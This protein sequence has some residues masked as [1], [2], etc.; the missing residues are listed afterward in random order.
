MANLVYR[1]V[2]YRLENKQT[3]SGENPNH[4]TVGVGNYYKLI[5]SLGP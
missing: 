3:N 1:F 2:R 5:I 4:S